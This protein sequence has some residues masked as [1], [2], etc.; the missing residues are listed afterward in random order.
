MFLLTKEVSLWG[1][2]NLDKSTHEDDPNDFYTFIY[3]MTKSHIDSEIERVSTK[4]NKTNNENKDVYLNSRSYLNSLKLLKQIDLGR[5]AV[6]YALM[7][8]SY[9]AGIDS[10]AKDILS[11]PNFEEFIDEEG[12]TFYMY[13][14]ELKITY[15]YIKTYVFTLKHIVKLVAP[16][17]DKLIR[18]LNVV[19]NICSKLRMYIPWVIVSSLE[20]AQSYLK[21]K[22]DKLA[23]FIFTKTRYTFKKYLPG[24]KAGYDYKQQLR[25]IRPNWIHSLYASVIALLYKSL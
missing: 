15:G 10:L 8:D 17:I 4:L 2:L 11:D 18:Y 6:K 16:K 1:K 21:E 5:K 12:K 13:K 24:K 25:S 23:A 7:K 22:E 3:I 9:S 14:N 20:I 19:V